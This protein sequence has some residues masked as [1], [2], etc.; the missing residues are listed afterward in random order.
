[1]RPTARAGDGVEGWQCPDGRQLDGHG[2]GEAAH[3]EEAEAPRGQ[4]QGGTG[5]TAHGGD[6]RDGR[7]GGGEITLLWNGQKVGTSGSTYE[8]IYIYILYIYLSIYLGKL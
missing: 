1:M 8:Y 2:G 6:R 3:G 5:G 4:R 7:D